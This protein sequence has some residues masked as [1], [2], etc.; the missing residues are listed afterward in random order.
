MNKVKC[1]IETNLKLLCGT[2]MIKLFLGV[3]LELLL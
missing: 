2:V 3:D 1:G